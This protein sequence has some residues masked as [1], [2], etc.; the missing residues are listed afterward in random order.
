MTDLQGKMTELWGDV[1]WH[2][3]FMDGPEAHATL[4]IPVWI[5][6]TLKTGNVTSV[7]PPKY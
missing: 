6:R 3:S 4:R 7:Q 2:S 1:L 5:E